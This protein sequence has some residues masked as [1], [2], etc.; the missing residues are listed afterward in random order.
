[1][2][3]QFVSKRLFAMR[4][5]SMRYDDNLLKM[6]NT[7]SERVRRDNLSLI[8]AESCTAG[9][10]P[11]L[12]CST[13]GASEWL[14]GGFVTYTKQQKSKALD[15]SPGILAAKTAVASD[16]ALL[17]ARGALNHSTAQIAIAITGVAGPTPDDDGNP[18]GLVYC[19]VS[20]KNGPELVE[21]LEWGEKTKDFILG[22][23]M[24]S[25]IRLALRVMSD[26]KT[27]EWQRQ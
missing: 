25:A 14:E 18:V 12:L 19:A 17:M 16:V 1:M 2:A 9:L 20:R 13:Q 8:T 24:E 4:V 26:D 15:V 7:L 5:H 6:A 22:H 11:N 21:R 3:E 23:T 27:R 10:L